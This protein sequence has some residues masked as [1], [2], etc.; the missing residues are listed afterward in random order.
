MRLPELLADVLPT[1]TSTF[2]LYERYTD[3]VAIE[4]DTAEGYDEFKRELGLRRHSD[5]P[6][7]IWPFRDP[8]APSFQRLRTSGRCLYP[9]PY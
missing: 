2:T 9:T 8:R 5:Y 4:V 3:A 1:T 6:I 7:S